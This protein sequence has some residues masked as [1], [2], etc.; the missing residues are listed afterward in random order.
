MTLEEPIEYKLPCI[1]QTEIKDPGGISFAEGVRTLL[2]QDPDV[3]F[4]G[5]IRDEE[6]ARMAIRASIDGSFGVYDVSHS[7]CFW[8]ISASI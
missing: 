5:E 6:T 1:R 2:R 3:I 4:I 8:C 7:K